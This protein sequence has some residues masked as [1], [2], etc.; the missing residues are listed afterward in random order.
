[1]SLVSILIPAY[2]ADRLI[3]SRFE[4]V[5][6]QTWNKK[7]IIIVD[8]GSTDNTLQIARQFESKLV[9]VVT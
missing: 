3:S 6:N 2:N 8:D 9:K 4:S 1:M 5:L 7:D